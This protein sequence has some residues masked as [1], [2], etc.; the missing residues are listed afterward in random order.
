MNHINPLR[1]RQNGRH[2]PDVIFKW[3][4]LNENAR[5]SIKT[6]RKF[7]VKD[8]INNISALVQTMAWRRPGDKPLYE[9]MM[10]Y[11]LTHICVTQS[12]WGNLNR[13]HYKQKRAPLLKFATGYVLFKSANYFKTVRPKRNRQHFADNILKNIFFNFNQKF[14]EVC[15]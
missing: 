3:I 7:V 6:S 5:I 15:W 10:F 11:L 12:Q 9:P 2:F 14:T 8:Q 4:F 13:Y 1:P